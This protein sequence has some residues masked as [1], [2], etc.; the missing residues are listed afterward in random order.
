MFMGPAARAYVE[1]E[2][3]KIGLPEKYFDAMLNDPAGFSKKLAQASE[4]YIKAMAEQELKNK[5]VLDTVRARPQPATNPRMVMLNALADNYKTQNPDATDTE[6]LAAATE[7]YNAQTAGVNKTSTAGEIAAQQQYGTQLP[8]LTRRLDKA[9]QEGDAKKVTAIMKE[10]ATARKGIS[11]G[12]SNV[13]RA[14]GGEEIIDLT[15][16]GNR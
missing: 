4:G 7:Q 8:M 10:I 2:A 1:Q 13:S 9:L 6:A 16:K 14:K 5:G 3:T 15:P 12:G 11:A